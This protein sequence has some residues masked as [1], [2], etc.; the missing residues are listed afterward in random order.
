MVDHRRLPL[1]PFGSRDSGHGGTGGEYPHLPLSTAGIGHMA[2]SPCA[3][4]ASQ[5]PR[6]PIDSTSSRRALRKR[7]KSLSPA[8]RRKAQQRIAKHLLR[9]PE[10]RLAR[11]IAAYLPVDGEARTEDLFAWAWRMDK[12]VYL[13]IIRPGNILVFTPWKPKGALRRNRLRILEPVNGH[14]RAPR[15]LDVVFLPLTG[16]DARGNRLGMGGS[17]YDRSFAF[18]LRQGRRC[19]PKLIGLAYE[20]QRVEHLPAAPWDVPLDA[21][22]TENGIHRFHR[23]PVL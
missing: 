19:P 9:L 11:H 1:E 23:K 8:A 3:H 4:T 7:R 17:F 22:L 14:I 16:F 2:P 20:C 6:N 21:V 13:P 12:R 10:F 5:S 15:R 18:R